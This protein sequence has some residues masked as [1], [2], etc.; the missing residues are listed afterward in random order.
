[1]ND[2]TANIELPEPYLA[3]HSIEHSL[4]TKMLHGNLSRRRLMVCVVPFDFAYCRGSF[5]QIRKGKETA[6]GRQKF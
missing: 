6:P 3:K 1:M 2:L 4:G 5:L